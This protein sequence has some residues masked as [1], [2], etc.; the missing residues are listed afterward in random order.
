MH[1]PNGLAVMNK[2]EIRSKLRDLPV[3]KICGIGERLKRR[4]HLLG[5]THCGQL[6]QFPSDVLKNEFGVIGIWLKM[7]VLVEDVSHI[8]Y[9]AD[10]QDPP[11]SVGH[12]QTLRRLS[13]DQEFIHDWIYLL[14][15]MVAV[16]LRRKDLQGRTVYFYISDGIG[17]GVS[18]R[19][20]YHIP[21]YDGSEIYRRCCDI[22][23]TFHMSYLRARFL[24]VSVSNLRPAD[25]HYLFDQEIRRDR[26]MKTIDCV[27]ERY[28]EWTVYPASL[29]N[30]TYDDECST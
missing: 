15:E 9:F 12:S 22:I 28:G 24:A 11:K 8:P 19:R 6:A 13:E 5:I 18:R 26:L 4:M 20:T 17:G 30:A 25:N 7:A 27:N 2:E 1:K 16:R 29:R 3:E 14:S 10:K 21:T 23:Q